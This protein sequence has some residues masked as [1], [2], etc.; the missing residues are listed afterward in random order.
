MVKTANLQNNRTSD[1]YITLLCEAYTALKLF[2][3]AH[4]G[5]EM[6]VEIAACH[7]NI[8]KLLGL[9]YLKSSVSTVNLQ[10]I[11]QSGS[12]NLVEET[13]N[14]TV[15]ST[16]TPS[17]LDSNSSSVSELIPDTSAIMSADVINDLVDMG[18]T[19][20][21]IGR[22]GIGEVFSPENWSW[23][24]ESCNIP[25]FI[26]MIEVTFIKCNEFEI[27]P[28]NQK[29]S[30][31]LAPVVV[32]FL[33]ELTHAVF[34]VIVVQNQTVFL[35]IFPANSGPQT[36]VDLVIHA[37]FIRECNSR[38]LLHVCFIIFVVYSQLVYLQPISF[39]YKSLS[40]LFRFCSN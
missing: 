2:M 19:Y 9:A 11:S 29:L 8:C 25:G 12:T 15:P 6:H 17:T 31:T 1:I 27:H 5:S 39:K 37:P 24:R 20:L 18:V 30:P 21:L 14:T 13:L 22:C 26:R 36:L 10:P 16:T 38:R 32:E 33:G 28:D 40:L 34:I 23:I 3:N 4:P 7:S 35:K